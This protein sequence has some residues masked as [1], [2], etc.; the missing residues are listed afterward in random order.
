MSD[1]LD[2]DPGVARWSCGGDQV[3]PRVLRELPPPWDAYDPAAA[4]ATDHTPEAVER[5]RASLRAL[6]DEPAPPVPVP[7][8]PGT[9]YLVWDAYCLELTERWPR[10][11]DLTWERVD[12]FVRECLVRDAALPLN[13]HALTHVEATLR[14]L[15]DQEYAYT[16]G[17]VWDWLAL[18]PDPARFAEW[19]VP[20]AERSVT[21]GLEADSA[22]AYLGAARAEEALTRLA[23][24]PD[25]PASWDD[26]ET[27]RDMLAELR[28]R[29]R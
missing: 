9:L 19:A 17:A 18:D 8:A 7:P 10:R 6:L 3:L 26:A 25:G 21:E 27:A 11:A 23:E 16:A 20:L 13:V 12:A 15:I 29:G 28:T 5:A 22:I 1:E 14:Y 24:K 4:A 2:W